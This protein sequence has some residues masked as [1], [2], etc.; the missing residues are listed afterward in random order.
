MEEGHQAP[1]I[2][3][4]GMMFVSTPQNQVIAVNAKTGDL[5]WR[6]QR[7][8]PEELFQLHPTN[9]GVGLYGDKVYLA[10]V[11]ACVVA[12][13]ATTGESVWEKCIADWSDGYYMTLSPLVAKGKVM[14]GVSGGEFGI[15]GFVTALDAETGD[16]AWKTYTVPAPGEPGS[17]TWKGDAWKTGG[18]P[19]WIQGNYDPATQPRLFRHRQRRP[20]DARHA[21][22]RQSLRDLGR[23]HRR[24]YRRHQGPPPVSLERRLGLGRGLRPVLVDIERDG[25]TIPAAVHAGRNGYL[26]MLERTADGPINFV[27]AQALRQARTSSPSIDPKTGRP[28]LRSGQ[29]PRAPT[30]RSTFCPGLWGGKDWPP[31]AYNPKT[32]LLYIPAN[33]NLCSELGGVPIGE[34]AA[35]RALHRRADRRDPGQP[36]AA[37]E[38]RRLQAGRDRP[39]AGL[40]PQDRQE[41]LEPRASRTAPTGDRC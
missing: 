19:V 25:R 36:A 24:R 18:A 15:R 39:A 40:G 14:V 8:L 30:R 2:V 5:L 29:D 17:E 22:R 20:L 35:G 9:R 33:D 12:L 41:G 3:N 27:D 26:W 11:D 16:E 4:N 28:E 31:E 7:E 21:A 32:G 6:Y 38:R 13:D 37:R 10:T 23:R 34:R 1:P